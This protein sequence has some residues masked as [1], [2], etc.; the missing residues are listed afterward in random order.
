MGSNCTDVR[1]LSATDCLPD[2]KLHIINFNSRVRSADS[3]SVEALI[4]SAIT[5]SS[6]AQIEGGHSS[7]VLNRLAP[8]PIAKSTNCSI[9]SISFFVAVRSNRS[10]VATH[11]TECPTSIKE[12]TAAG[13]FSNS[14]NKIGRTETIPLSV[15]KKIKCWWRISV[16]TGARLTPQLPLTTVVI[17]WLIF[18]DNSSDD[19]SIRHREYGRQ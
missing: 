6:D 19:R 10:M 7:L 2:R 18:Q 11:S 5:S 16:L 8:F 17:P 4:A 13:I 3:T 15:S 9:L 14:F 1:L 12:L